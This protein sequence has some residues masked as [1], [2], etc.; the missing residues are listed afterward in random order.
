[1]PS[2]FCPGSSG[3]RKLEEPHSLVASADELFVNAVAGDYHL[4]AGAAA[5]DAGTSQLA[6]TTDIEGN[7]RPIRQQSR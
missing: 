7:P 3:K 6:P 2:P 1:M 4:R 5:V